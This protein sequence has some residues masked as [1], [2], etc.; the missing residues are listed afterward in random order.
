MIHNEHPDDDRIE[1][2]TEADLSGEPIT[3]VEAY[4]HLEV[5]PDESEPPA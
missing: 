4:E 2:V 1:A 3:Q 5:T